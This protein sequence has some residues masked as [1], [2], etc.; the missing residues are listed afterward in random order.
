MVIFNY[1]FTNGTYPDAWA[2]GV[3][4]PIHKKGDTKNPSNYRGITLINITAKL[5]SMLLRNRINKWCENNKKLNDSQFGFRDNHSTTDCIFILHLIIQKVLASRNK[6]FCAFID[7]EKA[8]DTVNHDILWVKLVQSG[9]SCKIMNMIK[10]IYSNIKACVRSS[11][12]M[13]FSEFFDISIGLKQ[14][15]PLSPLLFLLFINDITDYIDMVNLSDKDIEQL[16]LYLLLFAD[17]IALFTTNPISL[18]A[19][20]DSISQYSTSCGLKINVNKTKVCIFETR[21]S[22]HNYQWTINEQIIEIVDSFCYLG[23]KLYYTG[24][25]RYA[26]KA[27]SDQALKA[28]HSLLC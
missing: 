14:G 22:H 19:Q 10:S 11:S 25:M 28:Y 5:F 8:F 12:T 17:D 13:N 1:I 3:I 27:L 16:S 9:L 4:V 23:V 7:Y 18:Q 15:E 6:L 20:L 26:V 2:K 24:N 21:K